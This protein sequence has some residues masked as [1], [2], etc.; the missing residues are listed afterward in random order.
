MPTNVADELMA[1]VDRSVDRLR[2]IT[3]AESSV[4]PAPDKWSHKQILGHL[5][6]SATNNHHRFVRAQEVD[7]LAFPRYE[8]E[9]WVRVQGYESSPWTELIDLWRLYNRHLAQV[10]TR[11]PEARLATLC[12]IGPSDPVTLDY[13]VRDYVVHIKHHLSQ[14]G[15]T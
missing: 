14:I 5:V 8:Q 1:V 4:K 3:D 10:I 11:I 2:R 7:E 6:D 12:K 15:I 13:L 9:H